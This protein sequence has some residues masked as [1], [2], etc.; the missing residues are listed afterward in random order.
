[1]DYTYNTQNSPKL[2]KFNKVKINYLNLNSVANNCHHDSTIINQN[3]IFSKDLVPLITTFFNCNPHIY[4]IVEYHYLDNVL[5]LKLPL[6]FNS[7][8]TKY[9]LNHSLSNS[10]SVFE[11]IRNTNKSTL[12]YYKQNLVQHSILPNKKIYYY[13]QETNPTI[14]VLKNYHSIEKKQIIKWELL[15]FL[16][17]IISINIKDKYSKHPTGTG[18]G[19][20][21]GTSNGTGN[22]AGN[23]NTVY[24]QI[25]FMIQKRETTT[26]IDTHT[27]DI[28]KIMKQFDKIFSNPI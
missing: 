22:G 26:L 2:D 16:S 9:C 15:P 24:C 19:N 28:N 23:D 12:K 8:S 17:L 1:M 4:G 25:Y 5:E 11:H 27:N 6:S 21:V 14:Q 10:E 18:N 20:G 7:N 13:L 3:L